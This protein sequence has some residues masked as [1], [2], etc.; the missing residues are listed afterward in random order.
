MGRPGQAFRKT[1]VLAAFVLF[2]VPSWSH[3]ENEPRDREREV[4]VE[5]ETREERRVREQE[6]RRERE[7]R[8]DNSGS[9]SAESDN[10]GSG[11]SGSADRDD[12]RSVERHDRDDAGRGS[13]AR[14]EVER[15]TAGRERVRRE[16]LMV[17]NGVR[18]INISIE[19]PD[20]F[21][22]AHV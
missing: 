7:V 16:V 21:V 13:S 5:R 17:V 2:A 22:L 14:F 9:G 12:D 10:S 3:E 8:I 11:S 1:A 18:V 6:D 19:G 20:N 15:D 4:R